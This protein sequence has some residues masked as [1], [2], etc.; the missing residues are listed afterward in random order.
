MGGAA[1]RFDLTRWQRDCLS[2]GEI[3]S[4]TK[5]SAVLRHVLLFILGAAA[6]VSELGGPAL[7]VYVWAVVWPKDQSWL[8]NLDLMTPK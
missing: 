1:A 8:K 2:N 4:K 5:K 6:N 7:R 3:Q